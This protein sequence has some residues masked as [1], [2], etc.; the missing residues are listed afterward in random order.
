VGGGAQD[1]AGPLEVEHV[2]RVL[3]GEHA[4]LHEGPAEPGLAPGEELPDEVLLHVEVLVEEL[5]E[6]LLVHVGAHPHQGELEEAR[7]GRRQDVLGSLLPLPVHEKRPPG[8][9]LERAAR[10]RLGDLPDSGRAGRR[11]RANGERRDQRRLPLAEE[12]LQDL[13]EALRR[14]RTLGE[15]VQPLGEAI[16]DGPGAV[17]GHGARA[18]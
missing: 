13:E 8:E 14:W 4:L 5:G 1:L 2:E 15:A 7:H 17:V 12:D 6:G 3:R 10:L 9:F 11:E 18:A 16:V